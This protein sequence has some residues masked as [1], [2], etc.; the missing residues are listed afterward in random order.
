M[1][2]NRVFRHWKRVLGNWK[3][4]LAALIVAFLFYALN[5]LLAQ[6]KSLISFYSLFGFFGTIVFFF[7]L[8]V[9]FGNTILLHSYISLIVISLMI[10]MLFSLIFYKVFIIKVRSEGGGLIA[11]IGVFIG[12]LIPG[13]AACSLGLASILGI[14]GALIAFL[15]FDGLELSVLAVVILGIAIFKTSNDSCKIMLN[16]KMKGG[17][18]D[19]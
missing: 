11:S 16:K 6:W 7:R 19:D 4:G 15:P 13:C 5:V 2:L 14:G 8:I 18:Q 17:R 1:E 3:Y 10:G 12:A 9:G